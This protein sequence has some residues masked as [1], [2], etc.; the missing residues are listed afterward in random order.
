MFMVLC[1]TWSHLTHQDKGKAAQLYWTEQLLHIKSRVC[2]QVTT[3]EQVFLHIKKGDNKS[4]YLIDHSQEQLAI[5]KST[6]NMVY[7]R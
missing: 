4:Y 5:S 3:K 6:F 1:L 2:Y 7:Q